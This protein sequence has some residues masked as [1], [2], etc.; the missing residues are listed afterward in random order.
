V[1]DG[2]AAP[3]EFMFVPAD[4][5]KV[6]E[7]SLIFE[8]KGQFGFGDS[9]LGQEGPLVNGLDIELQSHGESV[10]ANFKTT[11]ELLEYASPDGFYTG[12]GKG[13]YVIK[14]TRQFS[15]GLKLKDRDG[16]FIKL[17]IQDDLTKLGYGVASVLGYTD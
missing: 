13:T 6:T 2:S 4:D 10:V 8:D 5:V 7:L 15:K 3:V 16:D 17:T 11:R 9:F 14:A 12:E 1:V